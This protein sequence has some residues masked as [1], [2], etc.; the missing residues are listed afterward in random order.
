MLWDW[1]RWDCYKKGF[2]LK[3]V[4]YFFVNLAWVGEVQ[5]KA[6]GPEKVLLFCLSSLGKS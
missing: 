5:R 6:L 4:E 2:G 1:L 3:I